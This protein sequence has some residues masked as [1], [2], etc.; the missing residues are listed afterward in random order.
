MPVNP[1]C[2]LKSTGS[3]PVDCSKNC[4]WYLVR[5]RDKTPMCAVVAIALGASKIQ[6]KAEEK[7]D[8]LFSRI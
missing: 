3:K 8:A 7:F 2:P 6:T 1:T 4:A 5:K